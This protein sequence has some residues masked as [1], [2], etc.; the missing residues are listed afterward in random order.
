MDRI[1]GVVV[2]LVASFVIM[3]AWMFLSA[4][5]ALITTVLAIGAVGLAAVLKGKYGS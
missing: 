2:A 4:P 3:L 5:A 1:N